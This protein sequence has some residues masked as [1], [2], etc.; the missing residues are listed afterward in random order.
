MKGPWRG[1]GSVGGSSTGKQNIK[2]M[3]F[4]SKGL[5]YLFIF[6]LIKFCFSTFLIQLPNFLIQ[7]TLLAHSSNNIST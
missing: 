5:I 2:N 1:S 7:P 6:N 4:I 3:I